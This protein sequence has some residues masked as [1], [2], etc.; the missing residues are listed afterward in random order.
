MEFLLYVL[1]GAVVGLAVG[2]TG[3]GGGSLM[4]PLL[5]AFGFPLHIAVGTDLMYATITK[6]GGVWS[7]GKQRNIRWDLVGLLAAGSLPMAAL[8]IIA[9]KY[10][11]D[12][13]TDYAGI[14]TTCLGLMLILTS[15]VLIFGSR[16]RD[17][18]HR[19]RQVARNQV[20]LITVLMGAGLG[21]V[22]TL[23]SVGAGAIGTAVLMTLYP[24][25]TGVNIIG[26]DL[27]HAVPLTFVAGL[28][29]LFLGNVDFVLLGSLLIG[30][31]PAIY[32]GS[33]L[34][35]FIPDR[36]LRSVLATT[37]FGIGLKYA[38]F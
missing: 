9:L 34:A 30:S 31:L 15:L 25:L 26:T 24:R 16:L 12:E 1:A 23:S 7:Y 6:S 33:H 19:W 29:H 35:R 27:G 3:V 13:P 38:F 21:V 17:V 18:A 20:G 22:V 5:L 14:I 11:F 10:L 28:G 2:I 32:F 37:L 4:T 36:I 8:T